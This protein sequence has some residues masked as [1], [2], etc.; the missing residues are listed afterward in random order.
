MHRYWPS[1]IHHTNC[2]DIG[3]AM[4]CKSLPLQL[5][6]TVDTVYAHQI[7]CTVALQCC[8]ACVCCCSCT[9]H[10]V[11]EQ[12]S[13]SAMQVFAAAAARDLKQSA[14]AANILISVGMLCLLSAQHC[15]CL[16]LQLLKNLRRS[17]ATLDILGEWGTGARS[18]DE[19]ALELK[20]DRIWMEGRAQQKH[21]SALQV[22]PLHCLYVFLV[23]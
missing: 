12:Q 2:L 6:K 10:T 21:L 15:M 16:L 7:S 8:T 9:F 22:C 19:A 14:A 23:A 11:Q 4:Q 17:I 13:E 20:T 1:C 3:V 5:L 18:E